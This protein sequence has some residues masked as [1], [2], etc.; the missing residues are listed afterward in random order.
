MGL[1]FKS[2][3]KDEASAPVFQERADKLAQKL[4]KKSPGSLKKL[5]HVSEDLAALNYDRFQ[6]WD[7]LKEKITVFLE[8]EDMDEDDLEPKEL[9][10]FLNKKKEWSDNNIWEALI[11]ICEERI[12]HHKKEIT[13]LEKEREKNRLKLQVI[14][15]LGTVPSKEELERLLRYEGAIEKQYYKALNQLER[16]QRLRSGDKI[17][18]PLEV[19]IDVNKD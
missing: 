15:R 11:E 19:D 17:P 3:N 18:A 8:D 9:R 16:V 12:G 4:K 7:W 1:D 14:K 5:F 10:E 2:I 6:N 13:A